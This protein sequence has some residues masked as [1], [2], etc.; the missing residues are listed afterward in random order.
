[1]NDESEVSVR[2]RREPREWQRDVAA[3]KIAGV[4][5]GLAEEL[6]VSVTVVRTVFLVLALPPFSG[7]GVVLYFV[8]W[9][10]MP[11]QDG[12]SGLDQLVDTVSRWASD[13]PR[14]P[15]PSA[16]RTSRTSVDEELDGPF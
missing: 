8:L 7:I 4:C 6:G 12:R 14:R 9:F 15:G 1:M 11:V 16:R 2:R 5:A 10:L 3:R 13:P